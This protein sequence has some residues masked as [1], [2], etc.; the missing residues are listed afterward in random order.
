MLMFGRDPITPIAKLLEPKLK[1]YG[2]KGVSLRMDRL[3]KLYTVA[4]ENIRRAREKHPWQETVEHKFQVNDLVLV[5]D[6]E[7]A[8]FEPRYM[9]NYRIVAIHGK[10]RIEVQDVKGNRSI[11]RSGHVKPCQPTEKV[12]HQF[13]PQEVYEQYGR[14]SKLLLHP[15]DVPHV[16]LEVFEE[17]RQVKKSEGHEAEISSID[18][19]KE[20][21][22]DNHDESRSRVES[23]TPMEDLTMDQYTVEVC[24]LKLH[25]DR[26]VVHSLLTDKKG[27]VIEKEYGHCP[28][29]FGISKEI[30]IRDK[31]KSRFQ[32]AVTGALKKGSSEQQTDSNKEYSST[33][34]NDKSRS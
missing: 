22:V 30:D 26:D 16:P 21:L 6:P 27:E 3:R 32:E 2:E 7:S 25:P 28:T 34:T 23:E 15:K 12:C 10:N 33:D 9:P 11:R 14:T 1:F 29:T 19:M 13:P 24:V 31:S 4:A 8:V 20:I 5:K 18:D 17:Q